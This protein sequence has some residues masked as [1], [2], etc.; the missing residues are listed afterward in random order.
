MRGGKDG[1]FQTAYFRRKGSL[2]DTTQ[3]DTEMEEEGEGEGG[4]M[5]GGGGYKCVDRIM[6][7]RSLESATAQ[8]KYKQEQ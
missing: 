4:G 2:L 5:R 8:C 7:F 3:P 6:E 1:S